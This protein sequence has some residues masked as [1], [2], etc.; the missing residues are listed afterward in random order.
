DY[1]IADVKKEANRINTK[2]KVFLKES[3]VVEFEKELLSELYKFNT[4]YFPSPDFRYKVSK[5][6]INQ[7][8]YAEDKVE[9]FLKT[10]NELIKKYNIKINQKRSE[11]FLDNW[12]LKTT[13]DEI[14]YA[15]S[16]LESIENQKTKDII[17]IIL[18]RS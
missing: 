14:D 13:R 8:E 16:L 7:F 6:L 9:L 11:N 4:E 18:S 17:K 10:Y 2:L 15:V 3:G 5:K 12:F 1:D